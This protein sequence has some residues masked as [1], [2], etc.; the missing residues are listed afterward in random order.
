VPNDVLRPLLDAVGDVEW[1]I[2]AASQD[3]VCL[4]ELGLTPRR[5]FDTE[6]AGRLLNLPRVGLATLVEE[7][8]GLRMRKEHSAV[9][10]SKRPMPESWLDYAALDVEPLIELR[11]LLGDQLEAAG[12]A[13][14]AR[15]EFAYW[16]SLPF[17]GP[18][19][20]PW[21]RTSGIHRVRGRRGLALVRELWTARDEQ[22]R[23]TD[24]ASG[25]LLPDSAIID[26]A[27]AAPRSEREL[28]R[29]PSLRHSRSRRMVPSIW[30][31]V[32]R[33]ASMP[34]GELPSVSPRLDGPP[35]PRVWPTKNPD[36]ADRLRRCRDAVAAMATDHDLPAEN[37]VSPEAV[38]RLAW[39]PDRPI[40]P[41]SVGRQLAASGARRWQVDLTADALAD[42]LAPWT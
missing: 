9:D 14:W 13:E 19:P 39:K 33:V 34:D 17:P 40:H 10:W 26:V 37:L 21:R 2:H 25:R 3:L 24:T 22:A 36:A 38:R 23:E 32:E 27:V 18:R 6:L 16:A 28:S 35:H 31:A 1:V 30:A 12:K 15:Q 4:A 8:L 41:A 11:H 42:A 7:M 20:D 29:I 5:L